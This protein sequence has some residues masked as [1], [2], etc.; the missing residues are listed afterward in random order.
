MSRYYPLSQIKTNLYTKGN[1]YVISLTGLPYKGY[2]HQTS[3]G[4]LF[5][6][7]TPSDPPVNQLSPIESQVENDEF[8]NPGVNDKQSFW[9]IGNPNYKYSQNID[10]VPPTSFY[11]KPIEIDYELGEF[12][13]YFL[14][15][16]NEIK[17][18]EIDPFT[19]SQYLSKDPYVQYQLYL[20]LKVSWVLT[21]VKEEVYKVNYKT[22]ERVQQNNQ[23]RGFIEYFRGRFDKYYK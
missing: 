15:K 2:Y 7:K 16:S 1:E 12:E 3:N 17:F 23:L 13:R 6:G 11:P 8:T 20:P 22:V 10:P 9:T 4:Q 14:S 5:S 18:L 19:Y 21:G